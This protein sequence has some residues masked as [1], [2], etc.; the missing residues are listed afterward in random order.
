[1]SRA[2]CSSPSREQR[3]LVPPLPGRL[4]AIESA[5]S[6]TPF[7]AMGDEQRVPTDQLLQDAR[8]RFDEGTDFTVAVEE[9]FALLDPV[10]L[11]ARQPVRGRAGGRRRTRRS[12][13][14]LAGELIAS[15]VEI[16]TGRLETF[17]AVP[18]AIW[19]SDALAARQPRRALGPHPRCDRLAPV[20]ELEG[21][22][23]H[24]HAALPPE[25]RAPPLRRLDATT[26]S[27]ST[28]T[29]G[30]R[31]GPRDRGH[32][33]PCATAPGAARPLGE[34]AVRGGGSTRPPFGA[35]PDLHEDASRAAA[36]R[37]RSTTG[38]STRRSFDSCYDTGSIIESTQ[39]WWSVRPHH[40]VPA[41][42][43]CVSA[44]AR[45]S[46][47]THARGRGARERRA[48]RRSADDYEP[49]V[50]CRRTADG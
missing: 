34:L 2:G 17:A 3:D 43:R 40:N 22:A 46:W 15:E 21:P 23:D 8:E 1:M 7:R 5:V 19:P 37:T 41:P 35:H 28:S 49:A 45:P 32:L 31:R 10:T 12:S 29:S 6:T 27:A 33:A 36:S 30:S 13:E 26:P 11:D 20:G 38:T 9:E 4:V 50:R 39:I 25:R 44:T 14:H 16:S 48:S 47:R 18:Q 24:R 42:S